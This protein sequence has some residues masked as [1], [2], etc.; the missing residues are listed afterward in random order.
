MSRA[1][2]RRAN[3]KPHTEDELAS[4]KKARREVFRAWLKTETV[5]E[6]RLLTCNGSRRFRG[7][8]SAGRPVHLLARQTQSWESRG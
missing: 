4:A 2:K 6:R 7:R 5:E 8:A 3:T 1:A